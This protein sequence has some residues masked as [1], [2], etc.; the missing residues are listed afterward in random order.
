MIK[1]AGA[2]QHFCIVEMQSEIA[3]AFR[4]VIFSLALTIAQLPVATSIYH[5]Q[6]EER[7]KTSKPHLSKNCNNC[8]E[9]APLLPRVSLIIVA[10]TICSNP[11]RALSS[12]AG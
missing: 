12:F 1:N 2:Y 8:Q 4:W 7:I 11:R 10:D 3:S 6:N 5:P 9:S